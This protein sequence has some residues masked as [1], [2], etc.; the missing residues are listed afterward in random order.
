MPTE[1]STA[2]KTAPCTSRRS[3]YG[4]APPAARTVQFARSTGNGEAL[5]VTVRLGKRNPPAP[6]PIT[7]TRRVAM[8]LS[9]PENRHYRQEFI[10][11]DEADRQ[12]PGHA[13]DGRVPGRRRRAGGNARTRRRPPA[14]PS[15]AGRR[16]PLVVEFGG[17]GY[18]RSEV[19]PLAVL[20]WRDGFGASNSRPLRHRGSTQALEFDHVR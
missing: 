6:Q 14:R 19:R 9:I 16:G 10:A 4:A 13:P 3:G 17:C 8:T 12:R 2:V 18:L 5:A 1:I 7:P 11:H 20:A 15:C